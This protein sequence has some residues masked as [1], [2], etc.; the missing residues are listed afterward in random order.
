MA[1]PFS[2]VPS[3]VPEGSLRAF[4]GGTTPTEFELQQQ[5]MTRGALAAFQQEVLKNAQMGMD[6]RMAVMRALSSE[7]G[8]EFIATAPG[9]MFSSAENLIGLLTPP[10]P[11][12]R[13]VG[14]SLVQVEGTEAKE[15]FRPEQRLTPEQT[16]FGAMTPEQQTR[17]LGGTAEPTAHAKLVDEILLAQRTGDKPRAKLLMKGLPT[18]ASGK[19]DVTSF[20]R[21]RAAG[22]PVDENVVPRGLETVTPAQA[23]E[24]M[25][26]GRPDKPEDD[27]NTFDLILRGLGQNTGSAADNLDPEVAEAAVKI[28][29]NMNQQSGGQDFLA[30]LLA[31][32]GQGQ[33]GFPQQPSATETLDGLFEQARKNRTK[34]PGADPEG[35]A[36]GTKKQGA[37]KAEPETEAPKA[38]TQEQTIEGK[39]VSEISTLAEAV[40]IAKKVQ[41]GTLALTFEQREA[42]ADR[43]EELRTATGGE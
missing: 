20:L 2:G 19:L 26:V 25:L 16:A 42:L 24:A 13:T 1:N 14:D 18:E 40:A 11:D 8:S 4:F 7:V 37:P 3:L 35:G 33:A 9:E 34:A 41:E 36:P 17:A 23:K 39:K 10:G 21:L 31:Q 27:I 43:I 29:A 12:I 22:A 30:A 5:Q 38:G 32:Q 15:L 28:R 6:P